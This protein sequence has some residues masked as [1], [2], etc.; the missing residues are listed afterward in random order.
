M[1]KLAGYEFK[2]FSEG[3][4]PEDVKKYAAIALIRKLQAQRN[5]LDAPIRPSLAKGALARRGGSKTSKHYATG[6]LS[7]AVDWFSDLE[8]FETWNHVLASGLWDGMGIYFDTKNNDGG[9]QVMFH[10]DFGRS[11]NVYWY[12]KDKEMFSSIKYGHKFWGMLL[13]QFYI[14]N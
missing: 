13:R 6:R 3:E 14:Y 5:I 1:L 11:Q 12:R 10:T 4:F 2:D 8:P 9:R 7:T